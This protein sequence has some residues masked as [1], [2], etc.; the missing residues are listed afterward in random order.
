VYHVDG[1]TVPTLH[2][3]IKHKSKR[4]YDRELENTTIPAGFSDI[5]ATVFEV[6]LESEGPFN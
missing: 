6:G 1:V 4:K 3:L 2:G 5:S